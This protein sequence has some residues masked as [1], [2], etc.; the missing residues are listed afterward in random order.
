MGMN[1]P[2]TKHCGTS[3]RYRVQHN[4]RAEVVEAPTCTASNKR[5]PANGRQA[6]EAQAATEKGLTCTKRKHMRKS[7]QQ[8]FSAPD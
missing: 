3:C 2:R 1:E 7:S 8:R 6:S 5:R 4:D